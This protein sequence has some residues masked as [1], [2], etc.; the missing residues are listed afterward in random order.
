MP[1]QYT[2]DELRYMKDAIPTEELN[3]FDR[4]KAYVF[5]QQYNNR[6]KKDIHTIQQYGAYSL[7]QIAQ[8]LK[9]AERTLRRYMKAE[10]TEEIKISLASGMY[11]HVW[12]G[13]LM[14]HPTPKAR[15]RQRLVKN[16]QRYQR[17]LIEVVK[18]T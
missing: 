15:K 14:K 6:F 2:R 4:D 13:Y 11:A 17:P 12:A 10:Y 3:G 8:E 7:P 5:T 9:I 1:S 18:G 16:R